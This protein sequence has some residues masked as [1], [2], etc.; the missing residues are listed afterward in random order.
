[1]LHV[2]TQTSTHINNILKK[3]NIIYIY[4]NLIKFN[5]MFEPILLWGR[6]HCAKTQGLLE[7][8]AQHIAHPLPGRNEETRLKTTWCNTCF[9]HTAFV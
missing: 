4:I 5:P 2:K 6:G 3:T 9:W 7:D 1:M 8:I